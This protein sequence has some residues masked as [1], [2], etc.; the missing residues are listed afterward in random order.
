M[1][2]DEP[3]AASKPIPLARVTTGQVDFSDTAED[4]NQ[5][6]D[7]AAYLGKCISI[8][9]SLPL[10]TIKDKK[11]TYCEKN[12]RIHFFVPTRFL[13]FQSKDNLSQAHE[14]NL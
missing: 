12:K 8:L 10:T 7:F 11:R 4:E 14:G 2:R 13:Q 6:L 9:Q 3:D 1:W 5:Q